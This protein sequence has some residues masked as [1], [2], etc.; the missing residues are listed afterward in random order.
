[1]YRYL[2]PGQGVW[3]CGEF[4]SLRFAGWVAA[5]ERASVYLLSDGSRAAIPS[6]QRWPLLHERCL[7][8]ASG[9]LPRWPT[10]GPSMT[11]LGVGRD[12]LVQLA[13]KLPFDLKETDHA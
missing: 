13:K 10:E 4:H 9:R 1:M 5:W 3:R 11:Y 2:D 6:A 7:V 8:L 12:L